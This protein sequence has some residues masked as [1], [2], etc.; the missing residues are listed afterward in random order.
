MLLGLVMVSTVVFGMGD[1]KQNEGDHHEMPSVKPP[2]VFQR[3]AQIVGNWKGTTTS[4]EATEKATVEYTLTS[5]GTV[6]VEKT[7]AG[8][9]H[10]MMS[11]YHG[12]KKGLVMTHYCALGNQPRMRS[13]KTD[14]DRVFK[15]VFV[16]GTSFQSTNDPHMHQ[17]TMTLVDADHL[18]HEW[19]FFE[20]GQEKMTNKIEFERVR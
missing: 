20:G 6:L 12:D 15:F 16:D 11:M 9:P 13:E 3:L 17:L 7:F 1:A 2:E 18:R 19:V 8:T 14:S 4:P 10:E 5:A